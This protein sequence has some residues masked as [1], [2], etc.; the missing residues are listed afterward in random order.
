MLTLPYF[1]QEQYCA[2]FH[3]IMGIFAVSSLSGKGVDEIR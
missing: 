3:N 1:V 2:M